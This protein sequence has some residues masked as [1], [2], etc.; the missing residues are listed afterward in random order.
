MVPGMVMVL[1]PGLKEVVVLEF[2]V[3][4]RLELNVIPEVVNRAPPLP[5]TVPEMAPRQLPLL[6]ERIP[7]VRIVPPE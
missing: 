5:V 3:N 1:P 4:E 6:I 2:S 7:P